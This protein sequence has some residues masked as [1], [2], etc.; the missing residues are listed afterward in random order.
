M[1]LDNLKKKKEGVREVRVELRRIK[2]SSGYQNTL[3]EIL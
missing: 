2:V 3:Y 1:G